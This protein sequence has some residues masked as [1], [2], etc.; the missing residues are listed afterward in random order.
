MNIRVYAFKNQETSSLREVAR[1]F[2]VPGTT[3]SRR[4][5]DSPGVA[6][7]PS[8][9]IKRRPLLTS[10]FSK[11]YNNKHAKCKDPKIIR[12]WIVPDDIYNFNKTGFA[13]GLTT[14]IRVI[15]R[16]EYNGRRAL[17]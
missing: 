1:R 16:S 11:C 15:S 7:R 13:I 4:L 3:L 12:E 14:T 5:R 6:P 9:F 17:L 2:N 8:I 10:Q